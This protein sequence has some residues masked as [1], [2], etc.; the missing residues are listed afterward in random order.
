MDCCSCA[1]QQD[2]ILTKLHAFQNAMMGELKAMKEMLQLHCRVTEQLTSIGL[3]RNSI[4]D[5]EESAQVEDA[6]RDHSQVFPKSSGELSKEPLYDSNEM[7]VEPQNTASTDLD[8]FESMNEKGRKDNENVIEQLV[9]AVP[10]NLTNNFTEIKKEAA[11][12]WNKNDTFDAETHLNVLTCTEEET[13]SFITDST[14]FESMPSSSEWYIAQY[15]PDADTPTSSASN[16]EDGKQGKQQ[17]KS[18]ESAHKEAFKSYE[19][20]FCKRS[21]KSEYN[22]KYHVQVHLGLRDYACKIC[23]KTFG[24]KSH[25]SQHERVHTGERPFQC[26]KCFK[27]FSLKSIL[28]KHTRIH[29]GE[30]PF[31]CHV[32]SKS[33]S[34]KSVVSKHLKTHSQQN[35]FG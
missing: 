33:F 14:N 5:V 26:N 6:Q 25:L 21:Y 11:Q 13:S 8:S 24:F 17:N 31:Q 32:C 3:I 1:V 29:T 2:A 28:V 20:P 12:D 34:R 10:E 27:S 19:C 15:K 35:N 18:T 7:S 22:L 9:H 23:K 4:S 16:K 30:K